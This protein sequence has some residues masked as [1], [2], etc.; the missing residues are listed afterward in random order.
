MMRLT[1]MSLVAFAAL[2]ANAQQYFPP[3]VVYDTVRTKIADYEAVQ[4][5]DTSGN[6]VEE[7]FM[8]NNK[9]D[10]VWTTYH[11]TGF[12][13]TTTSFRNGKK[14]GSYI[15]VGRDGYLEEMIVYR[16]DIKY[17][18]H[19][20]FYKGARIDRELFYKNGIEDG[21]RKVYYSDAG[22]QEEANIKL[23]KREGIIKMERKRLNIITRMIRLMAWLLPIMKVA[24]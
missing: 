22:L 12:P 14:N 8:K 5:M 11:P 20:I 24:R 16:D 2:Q 6:V 18:P 19:R 17:G 4:L 21:L 3:K 7:G 23:G 10:G 1:L 13:A 9:L 15:R